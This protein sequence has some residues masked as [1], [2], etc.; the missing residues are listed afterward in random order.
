MNAYCLKCKTQMEMK[1]PKSK[2]TSNGRS[3]MCGTCTACG[4]KMNKFVSASG[5]TAKE[6]K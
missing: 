2:T 5:K 3:M 4:T 1:D 6:S